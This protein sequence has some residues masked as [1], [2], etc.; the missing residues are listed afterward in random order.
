M[1]AVEFDSVCVKYG[2]TSALRDLS[3][4]VEPNTIFGLLG[5]NG[6]GKTTAVDC[7]L[8]L[9]HPNAG[10]VRTLNLDP[11]REPRAV[12]AR[13]G[14]QLQESALPAR[15]R[16]AEA[17]DLFA[18]FYEAAVDAERLLA[19]W[20]LSEHRTAAFDTLSGGQKQRL[21]VALALLHDPDL[22]VLDE[23][24]AGLDPRAR[25]Q[26]HDLIREARDRDTTVILVT[27]R[28]NDAQA[29]CDR[30]ALL[31]D[32]RLV[33]CGTP[34]DLI[35]PLDAAVRICFT[36]PAG[37]DLSDVCALAGV[38]SVRRTGTAIR[39]YGED[40]LLSSVRSV[41]DDNGIHP[42]DLR[43]EPVS[44][45]DAFLARTKKNTPRSTAP[46]PSPA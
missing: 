36:A 3:L 38:T 14:V 4:S 11:T 35:A 40:G 8:G 6:A 45:E 39:I 20:D 46:M 21:A 7:L 37:I 32:G 33:A 30:A 15:I 16:V 9:T 31:D 34:R 23:V 29:L 27:H 10:S 17:V 26:T 28:M 25:L 1:P 24:F 13:T 5:P 12:R 2:D 42:P 18:A 44:L 19:D 41:L 43:A 22:V